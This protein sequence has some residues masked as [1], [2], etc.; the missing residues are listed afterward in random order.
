MS[1][2]NLGSGYF[3]TEDDQTDNQ[4]E[5][6]AQRG[7]ERLLLREPAE[8]AEIPALITMIRYGRE[9]R[10]RRAKFVVVADNEN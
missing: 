3:I 6:L 7:L 5:A 2:D 1:E 4:L 10:N 9:E 8:P